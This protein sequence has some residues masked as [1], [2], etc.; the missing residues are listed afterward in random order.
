MYDG[1]FLGGSDKVG[2]GQVQERVKLNFATRTELG[3]NVDHKTPPAQK[4]PVHAV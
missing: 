4:S 2:G 3:D 1:A